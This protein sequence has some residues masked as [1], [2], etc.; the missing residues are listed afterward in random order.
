MK[1]K[2][3]FSLGVVF[4]AALVAQARVAVAETGKKAPNFSL[5]DIDGRTHRLS[6]Y[7]GHI[8]ILEWT[9]P[10]CPFVR[11]HYESGNLPRL[12]KD[13]I[14]DGVIW[15]V[16][17]SGRPGAQGDFAPTA[18]KAWQKEHDSTPTAYLRDQ[19]GKVGKLYEA[20]TTPHMFV[21]DPNG[22]LIYDGA[23]DSI[24][25]ASQ[26]DIARADNYVTLSLQA[27]ASGEPMQPSDTQ[28][29]GCSVK[30]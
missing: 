22:I 25:S 8:V 12:Q 17:N 6:D 26:E 10:E 2:M 4:A 15:L 11:K 23:I 27:L 16:I 28:P 7:R 13:A 9:N 5:T 1:I 20:R 24:R 21:I 30:Y 19:D 3:L 29:Y 18:V 14:A